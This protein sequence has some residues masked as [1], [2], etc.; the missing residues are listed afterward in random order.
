M[1]ASPGGILIPEVGATHCWT[2]LMWIYVLGE[3]SGSDIKLGHTDKPRVSSRIKTVN[4]I[5]MSEDSYVMLAAVNS[6][7]SKADRR[8]QTSRP[9]SSEKRL[10]SYTAQGGLKA[11]GVVVDLS[12][13]G[14]GPVRG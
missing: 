6:S 10:V 4:R 2:E 1:N 11:G 9:S 3:C 14:R 8:T 12:P 7:V 5:Q 13:R